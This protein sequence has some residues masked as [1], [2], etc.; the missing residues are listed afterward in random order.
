MNLTQDWITTLNN[1]VREKNLKYNR[2]VEDVRTTFTR[3]VRTTD[4]V[5]NSKLKK[6]LLKIAYKL[7]LKW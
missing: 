2:A 4:G 7:S 3:M 6:E 1:R 5:L